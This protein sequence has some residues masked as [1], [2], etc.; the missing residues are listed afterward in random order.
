MT[1]K[2]CKIDK[3]ITLLWNDIRELY[4]SY[5]HTTK[6]D[7]WFGHYHKW[8]SNKLYAIKVL[9]ELR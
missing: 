1:P 7:Y 4:K 5:G 8:L 3:K 9:K 2:L 6:G